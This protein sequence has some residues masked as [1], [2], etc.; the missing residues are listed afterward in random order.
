MFSTQTK[1][2]CT[3]EDSAV[4]VCEVSV[5]PTKV[6]IHMHHYNCIH[7]YSLLRIPYVKDLPRLLQLIMR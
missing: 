2:P 4:S 7:A 3:P 6:I 5:Q 1:T